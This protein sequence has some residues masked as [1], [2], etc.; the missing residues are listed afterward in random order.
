MGEKERLFRGTEDL[1]VRD[2]RY[3]DAL[4]NKKFTSN[5][6]KSLAAM[7]L[8]DFIFKKNCCYDSKVLDEGIQYLLIGF[9]QQ[10][11][12][13]NFDTI[14]QFNEDNHL[15]YLNEIFDDEDYDTDCIEFDLEENDNDSFIVSHF[16]QSDKQ[17]LAMYRKSDDNPDYLQELFNFMVE[18][19]RD[20]WELFMIRSEYEKLEVGLRDILDAFIED[21][22][23][24]YIQ[25]FEW[26]IEGDD[27]KEFMA[28][29]VQSSRDNYTNYKGPPYE[30]KCVEHGTGN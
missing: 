29:N 5:N 2:L 4:D 22:K 7:R 28:L 24:E 16:D 17:K 25:E 6:S 14:K 27:F 26:K 23:V 1:Y 18:K 19:V 13:E 20:T 21:D 15:S 30:V 10:N 12:F 3:L 11:N 9:L 8:F